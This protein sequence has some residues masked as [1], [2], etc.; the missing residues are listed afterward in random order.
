M[1]DTAG[2]FLAMADSAVAVARALD[3]APVHLVTLDALDGRHQGD[4]LRLVLAGGSPWRIVVDA[5]GMNDV[6]LSRLAG[7]V[8]L[9]RRARARGGDLVLIADEPL[10]RL[11]RRSGL[12]RSLHCVRSPQEALDALTPARHPQHGYGQS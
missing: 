3:G 5:R 2:S 9:R 10:C 4:V 8:R 12:F 1:T 6:T 7:L 11:L